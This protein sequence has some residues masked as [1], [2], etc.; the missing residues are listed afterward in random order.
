MMYG[1]GEAESW[2]EWREALDAVGLVSALRRGIVRYRRPLLGEVARAVD[3]ALRGVPRLRRLLVTACLELEVRRHRVPFGDHHAARQSFSVL[4]LSD[5]HLDPEGHVLGALRERLR[6]IVVDLCV[7]T[8]DLQA[9]KDEDPPTLPML[10]GLVQTIDSRQG[11]VASL[12]NHDSPAVVDRLR[13]LGVTVLVN[14]TFAARRGPEELLV[15]GI[16]DAGRYWHPAALRSLARAKASGAG[17]VIVLS[18]SPDA[19]R[20]AAELGADLFLCGHTHGGQV[21]L[22]PGV[23]FFTD[24]RAPLRVA[25]GGLWREGTMIGVT[26]RGIGWINLPVRLFC[27]G[28]IVVLELQ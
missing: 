25:R 18:H 2:R 27:P 12:G 8:G 10:A 15:I 17:G 13:Q 5:L 19:Y 11:I 7:I 24:C 22:W 20:L 9:V 1:A 3:L 21:C 6:G 14:G 16:D 28:E 4:H 23:P 26:S